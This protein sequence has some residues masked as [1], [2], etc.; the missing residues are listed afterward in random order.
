MRHDALVV[1]D[2]DDRFARIDEPVE[3]AE[4]LLDI[5]KVEA[6][7]R[8]VKEVD[9]ALLAHVHS[10][11]EPLPLAAGQRGERLPDGEIA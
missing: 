9:A 6:S 11:L 1:L 3:Q 2:H 8:F 4:Q 7:G 10:Q 5:G